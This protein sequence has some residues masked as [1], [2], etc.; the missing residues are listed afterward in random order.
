MLLNHLRPGGRHGIARDETRDPIGYTLAVLNRLARSEILDRVGLRR[1]AEQTVFAVT[2]GGFR[3]ATTAGRVFARAGARGRAGRRAA[4]DAV[5]A[6]AAPAV[7][8]RAADEGGL[9]LRGGP[10]SLGGISEERAVV[11]GALV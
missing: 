9:A 11:A 10:E 5:V 3:T 2:R 7:V 8:L 6:G 1:Q 4:A